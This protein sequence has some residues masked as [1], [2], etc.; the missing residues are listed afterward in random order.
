MKKFKILSLDGGGTWALLQVLVLQDIFESKYPEKEIKGHEILRHFDLVVANSG[1]SLVLAALACNWSFKEI[2]HLFNEE[3]LKRI[4]NKIS[5]R[6]QYFPANILRL[7]KV[8]MVGTRYSTTEKR[9][10]LSEILRLN[11]KKLDDVLLSELPT[12]IGKKSLEIIVTTFD[13][14][15]NRAKIF[16]SNTKSKASTEVIAGIG[17]LDNISLVE[18]IHGSSTAPVNY[19]D[20]PAVF[21]PKNSRKRFYLWD[22]G[23]SGFN[24]PVM[25]GLTEAFANG[26]N[27]KNIHIL[28]IGTGSKLVSFEDT[29]KFRNNYYSTL[30]GK[31]LAFDKNNIDFKKTAFW[32]VPLLG[33]IKKPKIFFRFFRG[34]KLYLSTISSLSKTILFEPQT[35]AT[36]SAY[37]SLFSED[38]DNHSNNTRFIRLSPQI[39]KEKNSSNLINKLYDLDMDII[40]H[41][42]LELLKQ[43]FIEWKNGS[44]INEPIQWTRTIEGEY[45]F[46]KGHRN[47]K[48]GF[49]D[50]DWI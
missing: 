32:T 40:E 13:A 39:I 14:I 31:K 18:A 41:K 17:N 44:I 11:N 2:L 24:N 42:D 50:I 28:S 10:A 15:N 25:L 29:V 5:F 27:R 12:I 22:G 37:I 7:L 8:N 26:I 45:I 6:D 38:I 16:R 20:F 9:K 35:W 21:S 3:T 36:Y 1:G 49:E 33:E 30:L 23:L 46:A 47:Y 48:E 19:F 4:F 34:K 43:C